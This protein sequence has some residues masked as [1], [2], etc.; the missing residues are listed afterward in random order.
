MRLCS[1]RTVWRNSVKDI[2]I[3][4]TAK[5]RLNQPITGHVQVQVR[6]FAD[7]AGIAET[8]QW[9]RMLLIVVRKDKVFSRRPKV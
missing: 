1:S 4:S 8:P 5:A 3:K 7:G 6:A 9:R 2:G